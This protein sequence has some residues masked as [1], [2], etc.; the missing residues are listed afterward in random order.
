MIIRICCLRHIWSSIWRNEWIR[1]LGTWWFFV[2]LSQ[3]LSTCMNAS[4]QFIDDEDGHQTTNDGHAYDG[5]EWES[6]FCIFDVI[7]GRWNWRNCLACVYR[8]SYTNG[9]ET[10]LGQGAEPMS[11]SVDTQMVLFDAR[12]L[13]LDCKRSTPIGS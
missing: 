6:L 4:V 13:W 11:A 12:S 8:I 9:S 3:M 7:V 5:S 2:T 10:R 1:R